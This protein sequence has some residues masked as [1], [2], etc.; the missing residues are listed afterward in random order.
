MDWA[1]G[2]SEKN[3]GVNGEKLKDKY[4]PQEMKKIRDEIGSKERVRT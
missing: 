4:A 3:I 2:Q 1:Q